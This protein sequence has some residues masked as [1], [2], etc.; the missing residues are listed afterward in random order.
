MKA[1]YFSHPKRMYNQP[2][3]MK[4]WQELHRTYP[5]YTIIDPANFKPER[6]GIK[7]TCREC[8]NHLNDVLFPLIDN[9]EKVAVWPVYNTCELTCE[10]VHA[11]MQGKELLHLDYNP[12][13]EEL[14]IEPI[15]LQQFHLMQTL[16]EAE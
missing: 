6:T 5:G 9:C 16:L 12:R 1:I 8:M 10:L 7:P 11:F 2:L 4:V 13:S 3:P 14:E 15:T